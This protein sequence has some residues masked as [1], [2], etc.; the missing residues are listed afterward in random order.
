VQLPAPAPVVVAGPAAPAD[1]TRPTLRLGPL[2]S[3]LTLREFRKGVRVRV[4]PS[5][6][7]TLDT[8][9]AAVPRT[10]FERTTTLR[11]AQTLVLKPSAR[12]LGTPVGTFRVRVRLVATDRAA[13]RTTL[14]RTITVTP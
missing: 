12:F 14:Q 4:T 3:R 9:L 5:E 8:T 7:V 1:T 10:V 6:P 13:N 2:P 11:R